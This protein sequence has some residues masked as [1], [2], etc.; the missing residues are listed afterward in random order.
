MSELF[1]QQAIKN[2]KQGLH[3][4]VLLLP[5]LSYSLIIFGI[6]L[7]CLV[8]FV[9]LFNSHYAR[10]ETVIGWLEPP[11]G[12]IRV[13]AQSSGIVQKIL[14]SEGEQVVRD[15]PLLVINDDRVLANGENLDT[16]LLREYDAQR[17]LL[18]EQ[19]ARTQGIYEMQKKDMVNRILSAQKDLNLIN[20]QLSTLQDRQ[21]LVNT[22]VERFRALKLNGH[23]SSVEIDNVKTQEL[24]LKSDQQALQRSHVLQKNTI[25]Q[26][27]S[28]QKLLPEKNLDAMDQL[29]SR[30]S[31][32]A[33][34]II[35]LGGK[36]AYIVRAPRA[37]TV[38]NLQ[39]REGQKANP[40]NNIPILTLFPGNSNLTAH[41]LV[42]VR[43]IGFI[44][45]GQALAIRYE[46]FP[47]QK[48]GIYHG[49]VLQVSKTLLLPSELLDVPISVR[50]P[51]YRVTALLNQSNVKAYGK[52]F[53][54]K[55]GMA[56]SADISLGDRTLVQWLLEPI[57]SLTGRI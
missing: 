17:K 1:R 20:E 14:V 56:L 6:A 40:D 57:Y 52:D 22:Q 53:S 36:S 3:G 39:A 47:Y 35:Q 48:F 28:E 15:Q 31:D 26:L 7:W 4:E 34:K 5:R 50:E 25:E 10:K 24:A 27:Q 41:L 32:V 12:V 23:V 49:K 9:W 16:N 2:R 42:P 21:T 33:Q 55:P 13:Y 45:S 19:L 38:N 37:G 30:L 51:V 8:V 11:E 43:S 44:E 18:E 46:A 54:L 29:H